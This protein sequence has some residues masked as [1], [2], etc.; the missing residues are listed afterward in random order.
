MHW[1]V[2]IREGIFRTAPGELSVD[3]SGLLLT[4]G[5]S[6][7][8]LCLGREDPATLNLLAAGREYELEIVTGDQVIRVLFPAGTDYRQ[9]FGAFSDAFGQRFSV[10]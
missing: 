10:N 6:S 3:R 7:G 5:G 1:N 9:V 4:R 8:N 2:R